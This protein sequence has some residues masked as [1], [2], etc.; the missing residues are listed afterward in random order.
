VVT[1]LRRSNFIDVFTK[2][3]PSE[4]SG[5]EVVVSCY[6]GRLTGVDRVEFGECTVALFDQFDR[7]RPRRIDG[8]AQNVT[9]LHAGGPSNC[10]RD[11]HGMALGNRGFV[12]DLVGHTSLFGPT[13]KIIPLPLWLQ[14]D[15][16][17]VVF[18]FTFR[19]NHRTNTV[20]MGREAV[21][22]EWLDLSD[23]G[24]SGS[25]TVTAPLATRPD[26][27]QSHDE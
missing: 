13:G 17:T 19:S 11:R 15:S 18:Q 16:Q 24:V 4:L 5:D 26:R 21:T 9:G 10:S 20:Q 1:A 3:V 6:I 8:P 25:V 14:T 12:L 22:V 23:T 2:P 27:I 7:E